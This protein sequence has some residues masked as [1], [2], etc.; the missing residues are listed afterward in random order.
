MKIPL[1]KKVLEWL[2]CCYS[3][4]QFKFLVIIFKTIVWDQAIEELLPPD[5]LAQLLRPFEEVG[6]PLHASPS[7]VWWLAS[8]K[9][10]FPMVVVCHWDS[11]LLREE[12]LVPF[13]LSY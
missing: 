13:Y 7:E 2:H 10:T 8:C 12:C 11:L 3:W 5:E 9:R 4:T 6:S 1:L